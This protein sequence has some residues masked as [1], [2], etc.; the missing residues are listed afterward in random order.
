MQEKVGKDDLMGNALYKLLS[1][2]TTNK[3]KKKFLHFFIDE[4]I[5]ENI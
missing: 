4:N 1:F 3:I 5:K 2:L